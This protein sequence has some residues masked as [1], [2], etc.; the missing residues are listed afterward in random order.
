VQGQVLS[1]GK[2]TGP[3]SDRYYSQTV[4]KG[5]ED[6][7]SGR[8]E[9]PGYWAGSG[10]DLLME[11]DAPVSDEAFASLLAGRSP[12]SGAS[13]RSSTT[14]H[15]V[16][17]YDLTFSA[18][19][20]VS[21][22]YGV[23][24][25]ELSQQVR[26]A[27]DAAVGEALGYLE[28]NACW[29][30]R[31]PGGRNVLR[32]RGFVAGAF[33]HRTS[34][35]GDPALHTH[36]V[37]ANT[38][39]ADG[40]W[41]ALDGRHL[42]RHVKTAGYLYQAALRA[43]MTE[44]LGVRWT[45][46]T[47]GAADVRGVP[48]ELIEHF[49]E[50]R[51]EILEHMAQRGEHSAAAAHVAALET[52]RR[53]DRSVPVDRLRADW[54]A[55]AEEH[56]FG[57][58]ELQAILDRTEEFPH[59][60]PD[61]VREAVDAA[62]IEELTRESSA[63]DRRDVL[64][65]WASSERAGAR[66]VELENAADR[67]L[68]S[69]GVV[70]LERQKA[71]PWEARFSTPDMV[72]TERELIATAIERRGEGAGLVP[73]DEVS[74][75]L[76]K[77][78]ELA[79]EQVSMVERLTGSGDGVQVVRAAAGTGK[80]YALDAAREVWEACGFK[81]RGAALSARAAIEL[82]DQAGME[83]STLARLRADLQSGHNLTPNTVL[84]VD[85]AGTVGTRD[86]AEVARH[87][88]EMGAKLVLAGDDRQLPEI[89]AGGAFRALAKELDA[90]ELY[91]VRRQRE[92]WDRSA[93]A[94]LRDGDVDNWLDAYREH[95]RIRGGRDA[96]NTRA[97]LAEDW[98]KALHDDPAADVVMV[99][100]RRADVD[101]L[102]RRARDRL[103]DGG[104]LG[105]DD[106]DAGGRR[107]ATGDRVVA[108]RNDRRAGIANGT[109][110][111]VV[112]VDLERC[113]LTV[114]LGDGAHV[115]LDRSYLGDGHL[116]YGYALTA[117][118]AQGTTVDQAYVLGS[119]ELYREWGYTALSRHRDQAFFYVNGAEAQLELDGIAPDRDDMH[120]LR[121]PLAR[122][123]AKEMASEILDRGIGPETDLDVGL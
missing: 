79:P 106:L 46:V 109:R 83:T 101:D 25:D 69:T 18:P 75:H 107:F 45:S 53:K 122:R 36:V 56:G 52:R 38:T 61:H 16:S 103:R 11:S 95:G 123:R 14:P 86:L 117:H 3:D 9:A 99:A 29:T 66:V 115:D 111:K 5:R 108:C 67:W 72:A 87:A 49:S 24:T 116:D 54:R 4:A 85:E 74:E 97:Q 64:R 78:P 8:G 120:E 12:A 55:R 76:A 6:Y 13:L 100:H 70:P 15:A 10:V 91:D 48:R 62:T 92:P 26:E 94:E 39:E 102:N 98:W 20:S 32:G 50:R 42:Y 2:L 77:R 37:V 113:S 21:V 65:A 68:T 47:N 43:E 88:D 90:I 7:Y 93:L 17:G 84:V 121:A 114:E 41:S 57:Q 40:Q 31:G 23:G 27:H 112:A 71:G 30:R 89:E 118:R 59:P 35:A 1:I 34:R 51:A 110:G 19:K 80:T 119:D 63:F 22:L 73:G 105:P 44:R 96:E 58:E 28:R 82:R 60:Q 33:R 104:A 81:V